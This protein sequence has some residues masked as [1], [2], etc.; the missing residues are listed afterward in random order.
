MD[1]SL[2]A[3]QKKPLRLRSLRNVIRLRLI[4]VLI[5]DQHIQKLLAN[6]AEL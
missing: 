4:E 1:I 2:T 3:S 6:R 5:T